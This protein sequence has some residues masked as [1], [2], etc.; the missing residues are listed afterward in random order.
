MMPHVMPNKVSILMDV[1]PILTRIGPVVVVL[2][3]YLL[4]RGIVDRDTY[5]LVVA[6]AGVL[7]G[8]GAITT[9]RSASVPLASLHKPDDTGPPPLI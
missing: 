5:D 4:A 1:E 3:G 9:A 6:L 2:V 7:I 8:G